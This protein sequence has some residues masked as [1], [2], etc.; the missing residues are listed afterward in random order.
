MA[1]LLAAALPPQFI[2]QGRSGPVRQAM[3]TTSFA[4]VEIHL[5][6]VKGKNKQA[7][8]KTHA[9]HICE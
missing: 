9:E 5:L 7:N 8:T 6:G 4:A 2:Q 3:T 1:F